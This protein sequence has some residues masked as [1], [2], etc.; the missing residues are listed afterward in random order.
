MPSNLFQLKTSIN[1]IFTL[2]PLREARVECALKML[3]LSLVTHT[4][5]FLTS[6]SDKSGACLLQCFVFQATDTFSKSNRVVLF[7]V[8]KVALFF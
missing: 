1:R 6:D 4:K 3:D 2:L 8:L 5:I 7:S